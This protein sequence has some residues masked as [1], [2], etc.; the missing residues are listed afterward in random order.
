MENWV[1][2]TV[3]KLVS[4]TQGVKAKTVSPM[5]KIIKAIVY[6]IVA[7]ILVVTALVLLAI[8]AFRGL[9][10][11]VEVWQTYMILG[12]IFFALGILFW[13]KRRIRT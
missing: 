6:G 1:E 4:A 9:T 5:R 2:N 12:S 13:S 11:Y 3:E 7:A 10:H 8:A